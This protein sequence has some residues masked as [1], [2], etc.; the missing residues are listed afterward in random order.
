MPVGWRNTHPHTR[1]RP[2][3][4]SATGCVQV[5]SPERKGGSHPNLLNLGPTQTC[6]ILQ[7]QNDCGIFK[8][9]RPR[10]V[11]AYRRRVRYVVSPPIRISST[12]GAALLLGTDHKYCPGRLPVPRALAGA[13][14]A[15]RCPGRL[16][17]IYYIVPTQTERAEANADDDVWRWRYR[18]RS[19]STF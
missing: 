8:I 14:G 7:Q 6:S 19:Q 11:Y 3:L 2:Q 9:M 10:I 18:R 12:H 17:V 4:A 16:P 1:T 13:P 5:C 15:C